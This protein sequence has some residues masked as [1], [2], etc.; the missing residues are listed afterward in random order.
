MRLWRGRLYIYVRRAC[1]CRIRD[2]LWFSSLYPHTPLKLLVN[3]VDSVIR[4]DVLLIVVL[5]VAFSDHRYY[6]LPAY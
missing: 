6:A 5:F 2:L 4:I 1:D 3:S